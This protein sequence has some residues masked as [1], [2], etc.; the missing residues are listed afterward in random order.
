MHSMQLDMQSHRSAASTLLRGGGSRTAAGVS[1]P[2]AV[3]SSGT[4][5]QGHSRLAP[6][7]IPN[8]RL[9]TQ[10]L[11]G[12]RTNCREKSSL[13]AYAPT[14]AT[15]LTTTPWS[16]DANTLQDGC[17]VY[18]LR[19]TTVATTMHSMLLKTQ[20]NLQTASAFLSS[21]ENWTAVVVSRG[22]VVQGGATE[23]PCRFR[24]AALDIP[25]GTLCIACP[26][27]DRPNCRGM[28]QSLSSLQPEQH[29]S[30]PHRGYLT[31]TR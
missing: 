14:R 9:F 19:A 2:Y 18:L 16:P 20:G 3:Q 4:E 10:Y 6:H 11:L 12:C 15:Q 17:G 1:K 30:R 5:K 26:L 21:Q 24:F 23:N 25:Q 8:K 31:R 22:Y 27:R 13:P 28:R 7:N 29:S